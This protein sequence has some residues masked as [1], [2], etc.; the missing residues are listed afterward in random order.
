[1]LQVSHRVFR[2][3]R[4]AARQVI[5]ICLKLLTGRGWQKHAMRRWIKFFLGVL[6]AVLLVTFF[7]VYFMFGAG[8][9]GPPRENPPIFISGGTLFRAIDATLEAN[10]GI[11]LENGR[12]A[13]IGIDCGPAAGAR[14]IDATGLFIM[15]GMIELHGH[16]AAIT[17][18]NADLSLTRLGWN[19]VRMRP[20]VR[21]RLHESGITTFR[22]V[23]DPRD[24]ILELKR[25]LATGEIAGPR[26]FVT[27]PIFTAP[28]GH[29]VD[30]GKEANSSGFGGE[31]VFTS[32]D[33]ASIR[34]EVALLAEQGADG[35][36]AVYQ[37]RASTN[38]EM[39]IPTL[40]EASLQA[41]VEEAHSHGLWVAVHVGPADEMLVALQAG[42]D[43]IE[44]GV[45]KG[46]LISGEMLQMLVSNRVVYVPTLVHESG[47]ELNL[48]ALLGAGV[49][50]GVG[51]DTNNPAMRYGD[52]YHNELQALVDAG[53]P[54]I[55]VLLAAT[56][57][58][59]IALGRESVLGTLETGGFADMLLVRG[60]PWQDIGDLRNI[61]MVIQDGMVV[62]DQ[63]GEARNPQ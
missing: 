60:E 18:D 3:C 50:I 39:Q 31:L 5:G 63:P 14:R 15:P 56:R 44:H 40:S 1:M 46:N 17:E 43:T 24:Y 33:P 11:V 10:P 20:D 12:I 6:T 13:C 58:G 7:T 57:N 28:D 9:Y 42:A 48:P 26:M 30:G 27:G 32:D 22:S 35:I 38:D 52:S 45:R 36:K 51:T 55:D 37:R 41:L 8:I 59:A 4:A 21:R 29:P 25:S 54:A 34:Q 19:M 61:R 23:G 62:V 16:F 2:I 49:L 47:G 53:M